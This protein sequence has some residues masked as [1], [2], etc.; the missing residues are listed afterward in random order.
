MRPWETAS[1][2]YS[3]CIVEPF[4]STPIA[5]MASKGARVVVEARVGVASAVATSSR[6]C[7][8]AWTSVDAALVVVV[9]VLV[10]SATPLLLVLE[11]CIC[12]TP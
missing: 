4:I 6:R 3:K 9:V 7:V 2:M 5:M 12:S 8:A 1:A 10:F 11:V